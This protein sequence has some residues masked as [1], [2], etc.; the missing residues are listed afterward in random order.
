MAEDRAAEIS[1]RSVADE[2]EFARQ[3]AF[4]EDFLNNHIG[5][6]ERMHIRGLIENAARNREYETMVYSF[7]SNLCTDGGRAINNALPHWPE[8]LQGKAREIYDLFEE[9]GKPLGY[10][11]RALVVTFPG[12]IPGDIGFFVSWKPPIE[13]HRKGG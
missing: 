6:D 4:A 11:F 12:G 3:K 5:P 13:T 10:R 7:P 9:V 2:A 1:Q 8:T